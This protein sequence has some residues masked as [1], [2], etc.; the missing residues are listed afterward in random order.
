MKNEII[1]YPLKLSRS[2][3]NKVLCISLF[4]MF[5]AIIFIIAFKQNIKSAK[6]KMIAVLLAEYVYITMISM[7]I[8]RR[9]FP[10]YQ[11]DFRPFGSYNKILNGKPYLIKQII[12]NI[13][14]RVPIGYFACFIIKSSQLWKAGKLELP[15]QYL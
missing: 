15:V 8:Y 1:R 5:C 6:S 7:V 10:N 4:I 12:I 11:F 9:S 14:I 3:P 2:I 13:L